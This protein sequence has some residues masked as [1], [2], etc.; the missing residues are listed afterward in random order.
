MLYVQ[1]RKSLKVRREKKLISLQSANKTLGKE[2][3]LLSAKKTL[4]C[5]CK[6]GSFYLILE[7]ICRA[8]QVT[9][10]C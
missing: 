3:G 1:S 6:L 8:G 10:L 4:G 7:I 2:G 9:H 5:T